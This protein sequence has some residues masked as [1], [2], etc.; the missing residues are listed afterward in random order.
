[1]AGIYQFT[2]ARHVPIEG[3]TPLIKWQGTIEKDGAN[4]EVIVDMY[5]AGSTPEKSASA[6]DM[7]EKALRILGVDVATCGPDEWCRIFSEPYN[8]LAGK[9]IDVEETEN[10]WPEGSGKIQTQY[11]FVLKTVATPTA[12]RSIFNSLFA[13]RQNQGKP[14]GSS[15]VPARPTK[16]PGTQKPP[17]PGPKPLASSAPASSHAQQPAPQPQQA[18]TGQNII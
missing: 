12:T 6:A 17:L 16:I 9:K 7:S 5:T 1:M 15:N 10:E 14:A 4:V 8:A 13:T 11:R 3:G 2:V 18:A